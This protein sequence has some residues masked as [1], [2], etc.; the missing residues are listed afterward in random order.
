[1]SLNDM[2]IGLERLVYTLPRAS[3]SGRL[4]CRR[5]WCHQSRD[6]ACYVRPSWALGRSMAA[7]WC[8]EQQPLRVS[9]PRRAAKKAAVHLP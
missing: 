4:H 6:P 7:S 5:R 8:D 1:M 2:N 9:A 3:E